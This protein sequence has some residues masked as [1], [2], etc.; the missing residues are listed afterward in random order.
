MLTL[1][2]ELP[3]SFLVW[4]ASQEARFTD[5]KILWCNWDVTE[6]KQLKDKIEGTDLLTTGMIGFP[7][8]PTLK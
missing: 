3:A 5:G 8:Y 1:V 6:L 4:T 7:D 2:V